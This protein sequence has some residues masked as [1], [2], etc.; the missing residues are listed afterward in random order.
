ML[1]IYLIWKNGPQVVCLGYF[2]RERVELKDSKEKERSF[3]SFAD[4]RYRFFFMQND[5][6]ILVV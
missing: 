3:M 5:P 6:S 4:P 1:I 2:T